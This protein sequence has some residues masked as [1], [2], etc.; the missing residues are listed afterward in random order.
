VDKCYGC[1]LFDCMLA[2]S[3]ALCCLLLHSTHRCRVAGSRL[4]CLLLCCCGTSGMQSRGI[5]CL[6]VAHMALLTLQSVAVLLWH[7]K[8]WDAI[9]GHSFGGSVVGVLVLL[10][11]CCIQHALGVLDGTCVRWAEFA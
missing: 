11:A 3:A 6:Y 10:L 2:V 4:C 9:L 5:M 7:Q 1:R 8:G